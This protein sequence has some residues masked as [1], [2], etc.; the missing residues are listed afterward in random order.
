M[1][2]FEY[3]CEAC[4][5]EFEELVFGNQDVP[6][7]ACGSTQTGKLMSRCRFKNGGGRDSL[8]EASDPSSGSSGV[9]SGSSCAGCSGGNCATCH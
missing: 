7:P 1:P 9:S 4:G 5:K 2:I 3:R 8:G 6:C